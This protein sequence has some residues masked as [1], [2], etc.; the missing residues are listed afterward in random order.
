MSFV[1]VRG[2]VLRRE[3]VV[4]R[5]TSMRMCVCVWGGGVHDVCVHMLGIMTD[6]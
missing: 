2:V 6:F 1:L 3:K 4:R 5:D